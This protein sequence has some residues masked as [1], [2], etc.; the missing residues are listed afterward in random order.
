MPRPDE[1]TRDD[2]RPVGAPLPWGG[3]VSPG[4]QVSRPLLKGWQPV[5]GLWFPAGGRSEAARAGGLVTAWRPGS[6]AWRFAQGDLLRYPAAAVVPCEALSGWPLRRDGEALCSAFLTGAERSRLPVA[7]LWLVLGGEVLALHLA[8]AAP[9]DPAEWLDL[10]GLALHD[11][12][13]CREALPPAVVLAPPARSVREVL[14]DAVPPASAEQ[15]AFLRRLAQRQSGH[16]PARGLPDLASRARRPGAL[17]LLV[18]MLGLAFGLAVDGWQGLMQLLAC[19]GLGLRGHA[20]WRLLR[21]PPAG[22]AGAQ[23]V[24]ARPAVP[25]RRAGGVRPQRWRQW[26]VR[27]AVT[28]RLSVWLG[29]QQA[30]YLRR[31]L[32]MFDEGR[33]DDALRHA[34]PLGGEAGSLGQAFGVPGPRA[35]LGLRRQPG[36]TTTMHLGDDLESHLRRLYRQAFERLAREGRVD[37]AVFVLAELLQARREALDYLEAHQRH[38]QAAELA[39]AWDQPADL[40]VRLHCLAGDWR[41]AVAVARRDRAF[42]NAVLQLEKKWPDAARRLRGEW[43]EALAQQGDWLAAVNAVWPVEALRAKA[44][45]WLQAAE[46]AEGELGARALVQRALLLPDTLDRHAARLQALRDERGLHRERGALAEA[47]LAAASH[48]EAPRAL[49]AALTGAVLADQAQGQGRLAKKALQS[50]VTLGGDALLQADLPSADW[51]AP[52]RQPL[53]LRDEVLV[54]E[55]PEPGAQAL[56]DAVP[57]GDRRHLVALGEAG[58]LIV[59]AAGR[60]LTRFNVPAQR[61]VIA[62]SRQQALA[63]A[64]RDGLWRVSRLDLVRRHVSDLGVCELDHFAEE[65]DGLG[66]TV[67]RGSRLQ[68]LDTGR[69]LHEVLW[70]VPD[71]PGPVRALSTSADVEQV[72]VGGE[73]WTYHLPQRRLAA[74]DAWPKTAE[75]QPR[76]LLNAQRGLVSLYVHTADPAAL[77]VSWHVAGSAGRIALPR[78]DAQQVLAHTAGD[79]LVL[80]WREAATDASGAPCRTACWIRLSAGAPQATPRATVRWPA[81]GALSLRAC[82]SA[83]LLFDDRGRLLQLDTASSEVMRLAVQ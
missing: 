17:A 75:P 32:R 23:A 40:I 73:L 53:S 68:V 9:L 69:G 55:A 71:L 21:Q 47:L 6:S 64:H 26:L 35:D 28:S 65:F 61:L 58:V 44:L 70:Q 51:P 60:T 78:A 1:G 39:L 12:Y 83:W 29:Q 30:A 16:R 42:A 31:M 66:W 3:E 56:L 52:P 74:R 27:L 4:A 48:G 19:V 72:V 80:V 77:Q 2:A 43:G 82:G 63:L 11:T 79:W 49:A 25:A 22:A 57:L 37:E 45:E 10:R 36:A 41:R 34:I 24:P 33:L 59:D 38:A 81:D 62:H 8:D 46:S 50:L 67:A 5:A 76:R 7:D 18:L 13:D 15:A 54:G 20:A 14:G